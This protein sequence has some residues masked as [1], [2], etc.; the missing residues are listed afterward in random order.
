MDART[1]RRGRRR[2]PCRSLRQLS[3]ASRLTVLPLRGG[4]DLVQN[5][6]LLDGTQHG[7]AGRL[8]RVWLQASTATIYAHR[9][10]APN[11][12]ATG[13]LGGSELNAPDTWRFSI[14]VARQ[15]EQALWDSV[16]PATRKVALR[17]AMVMSPDTG[18][19]FDVLLSLVRHGLGGTNGDGRQYLSWIHGDDFTRAMLFLLEDACELDGPVNI[20]AP[21]PVPNAAF[22]RTL[23]EA[24][25]IPFG[26]PASEWMLEIG[27]RLLRTESE[28]VLKSRR[29]VP[30]RLLSAGFLF[31]FPD[32]PGAAR[33]LCRRWRA[34]HSVG[35]AA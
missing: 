32:W 31:Q 2:K 3:Q 16:T 13:I 8:P 19:V 1:E 35:A 24:W 11:D 26:L 5:V 25:G 34:S 6:L 27:T 28:L 9:C 21:E 17:S 22:L 7:Q 12:E 10:D 33:D 15:W 14:D 4:C 29:V 23:R 20:C 30:G 18:G